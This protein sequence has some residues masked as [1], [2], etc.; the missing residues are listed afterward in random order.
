MTTDLA[1]KIA[2]KQ[3]AQA[4]QPT[5]E[6]VLRAREPEIARAL[7]AGV[8][9]AEFIQNAITVLRN[10]PQLLR[11]TLPSLMGALY[12]AAQLKLRVGGL[13][14]Q[15]HLTPRTVGGEFVVVPIVDYRG[16]LHL[17]GNTRLFSKV[18]AFTIHANDSW[19]KAANSERGQFFDHAE[20]V[21]ERGEIIG[22]VGL[23]KLKGADD[24]AWVFLTT[25]EVERDHRPKSWE[26][27]PWKTHRTQQFK[28]T[29][30]RELFKWVPNSTEMAI[31]AADDE[32]VIR[33]IEGVEELQVSHDAITEK[34]DLDPAHP[35]YVAVGE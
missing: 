27:T 1:N 28:K 32:A 15:V 10:N 35:D 7:G 2:T 12:L 5:I 18:E 30:I 34:P 17:I 26:S 22:V 20:A 9:P 25:E 14:P 3:V 8:D 4:K 19:E 24:T 16:Y 21:G 13:A 11:C 31:A 33:K 29:A 23:A 6:D